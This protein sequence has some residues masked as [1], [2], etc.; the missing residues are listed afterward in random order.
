M[1][2]NGVRLL[3]S[4][5]LLL[6]AGAFGLLF[7]ACRS[8][9]PV[10]QSL[11]VLEQ[12]VVRLEKSVNAALGEGA[13]RLSAET[14]KDLADAGTQIQKSY[15]EV[16]TMGSEGLSNEQAKRRS[17]LTERAVFVVGD[18]LNLRLSDEYR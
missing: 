10:D 5:S 1:R 14:L 9:D 2:M 6:L 8:G 3:T 7:V 4:C 11:D 18:M 15:A 17:E 16:Q 12:S 13:K